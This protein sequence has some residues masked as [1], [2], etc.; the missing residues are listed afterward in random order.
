M[1][2]PT[3]FSSRFWVT[4]ALLGALSAP[5]GCAT[6]QPLAFNNA[7][8]IKPRNPEPVTM[9]V[10]LPYDDRYKAEKEGENPALRWG[11]AVIGGMGVSRRGNDVTADANFELVGGP[12]G[13]HP[14]IATS[15]GSAL[16]QMLQ[17]LQSTSRITAVPSEIRWHCLDGTCVPSSEDVAA[18]ARMTQ[19]RYVLAT[20]VAH[21]YGMDF[22]NRTLAVATTQ[23]RQGSY[24]VQQTTSYH[25]ELHS[26]GYGVCVL[27][28]TL[29]AVQGGRVVQTW[30][31]SVSGTDS[32]STAMGQMEQLASVAVRA[33]SKSLTTLAQD[34]PVAQPTPPSSSN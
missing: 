3:L 11:W 12:F 7:A 27:E 16:I 32:S 6:P 15:I 23:T 21:L 29:F 30:R 4:A 5:S 20:R 34:F 25:S 13:N 18:V 19:A 14:T 17:S 2:F 33:V 26:G 10:L 22:G 9:A 31:H 8:A 1:T 28:V 24:I